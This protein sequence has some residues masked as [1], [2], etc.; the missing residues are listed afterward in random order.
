MQ[1]KLT[2]EFL[3]RRKEK[4]NHFNRHH[5]HDKKKHFII[6]KLSSSSSLIL[7]GIKI[8]FGVKWPNQNQKPTICL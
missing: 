7:I 5:H 1:H 8:G 6:A 2:L 3:L 4:C